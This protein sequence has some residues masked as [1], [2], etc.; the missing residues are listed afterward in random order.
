MSAIVSEILVQKHTLGEV[1]NWTIIWGQVVSRIF[2][3]KIIK[4]W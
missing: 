2:I 4:M 1:G 3:P